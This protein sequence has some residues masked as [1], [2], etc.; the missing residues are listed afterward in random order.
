L[1]DFALRFGLAL[2]V[3]IVACAAIIIARRNYA[4]SADIERNIEAFRREFQ[5]SIDEAQAATIKTIRDNVFSVLKTI[6]STVKDLN[7]PCEFGRAR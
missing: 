4:K 3:V 5:R 7:P 1:S 6:N 2:I